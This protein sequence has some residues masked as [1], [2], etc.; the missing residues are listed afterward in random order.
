MTTKDPTATQFSF[1][2]PGRG[3]QTETESAFEASV[4]LNTD[5]QPRVNL[6]RHR[7]NE[8]LGDRTPKAIEHL[9][10]MLSTSRHVVE[11]RTF[12]GQVLSD[13]DK[14]LIAVE[15]RLPINVLDYNGLDPLAFACAEVIHS[16]GITKRE[17]A[18]RI[19]R[20]FPWAESGRP[21]NPVFD[22]GF[23]TADTKPLTAAEMAA[24]AQCSQETIRQARRIHSCG[25]AESVI[26]GTT[27]FSDALRNIKDARA[28]ECTDFKFPASDTGPEIQSTA[29]EADVDRGPVRDKHGKHPDSKY[30]QSKEIEELK[31]ENARLKK[32]MLALNRENA[33]LEAE[34]QKLRLK[35]NCLK[36]LLPELDEQP[37]I[38]HITYLE[39]RLH[40]QEERLWREKQRTDAA[41][42]EL[43]RLRRQ[44]QCAVWHG[45]GT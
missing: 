35:E 1:F 13:W 27:S 33:R 37:L 16:L 3:R 40:A 20:A 8:A 25:L 34:L 42:S 15:Q 18:L 9:R 12:E 41:E 23:S 32:R 17:R 36:D 2:P 43:A 29:H 6:A 21:T 24:L 44:P 22:T 19:V 7:Y 28:L 10:E 14:Y 11:V 31:F 39:M 5:E 4:G 26:E 30:L 45:D 38:T